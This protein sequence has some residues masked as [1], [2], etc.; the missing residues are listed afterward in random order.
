MSLFLPLLCLV[1]AIV[2]VG[3]FVWALKQWPIDPTFTRVATSI[4]IVALVI[5]AVIVVIN[6]VSV[7]FSGSA[8]FPLRGLGH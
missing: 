1:G 2:I 5:I 3:A 6:L 8:A 7:A 4:L